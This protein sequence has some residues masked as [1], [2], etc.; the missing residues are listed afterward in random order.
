[1]QYYKY[2]SV[3]T[4]AGSDSG[5]GAGIQADLKTFAALGCFGTSAIT[6]VTAQNTLGITAIHP[7]SPAM[8]QSQITAV[9]DDI[10]PVAIKIGMLPDAETVSIVAETLG[11]YKEI[12]IILD[13]VIKATAGI[14]LA[15]AESIQAMRSQLFPLA[16]LITPNLD[17]AALFGGCNIVNRDDMQAVAQTLLSFGSRA[18]LVKGG[19]LKGEMLYNAYA[20]QDGEESIFSYSYIPSPNTHGT[21]CTL[22]SAIAAYIARGESL[23]DAIDSAGNYVN[24]AIKEGR[25]VR[26][27]NGCGPLNHFFKPRKLARIEW[28]QEK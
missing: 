14:A 5:G 9:M 12:P 26:T 16:T 17:E 13:P 1:M 18:V 19:H 24:I 21:G 6:A 27:G 3:L 25:N 23:V 4:I 7:I 22:A 2:C 8:I 20:H 15:N 28:L 10:C 11:K